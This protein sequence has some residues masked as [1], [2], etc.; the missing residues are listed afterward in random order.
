M[1]DK[2]N[3][4]GPLCVCLCPKLNILFASVSELE[5]EQ[6]RLK[7]KMAELQTASPSNILE[8]EEKVT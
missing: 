4:E 6:D 8:E 1:L 5:A 7:T 3:V 2:G